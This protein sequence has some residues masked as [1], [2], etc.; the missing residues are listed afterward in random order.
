MLKKIDFDELQVGDLVLVDT[1]DVAG[2]INSPP[3]EKSFKLFPVA[4]V[5]EVSGSYIL[6]GFPFDF[7][8]VDYPVIIW[9][10]E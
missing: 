10:N 4:I 3:T 7:D 6:K 9:E 1:A 8:G 2:L 5:D